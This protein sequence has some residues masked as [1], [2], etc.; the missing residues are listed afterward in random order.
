MALNKRLTDVSINALPAK[1]KEYRLHDSD[2]LYIRVKPSG[3]KSWQLRAKDLNGKWKWYGIG[4][5]PEVKLKTAHLK[6]MKVMNGEEVLLTKKEKKEEEMQQQKALFSQLMEEWL[7]TKKPVWSEK[8]YEKEVQSIHKHLIPV[9]GQLEFAEITSEQWLD[10][11]YEKQC[12]EGIPDRIEKL[13]SHCRNAYDLAK[14]KGKVLYNPL[15]GIGK[16]L[17]KPAGENLKFMELEDIPEMLSKIRAYSARRIGI[18]LEL[19]ILLF[20]RPQELRLA[21]WDHFDFNKKLWIKPASIMKQRKAHAVPLS[22]QA[23]TLLAELKAISSESEYLFPSRDSI[24][25][26]ISNLTFNA[27]LNRLGYKGKQHPHGFRHVASTYL[28]NEF[29]DKDQVVEAALSHSKRG[30]KSVYDKSTHLGERR[31]MMQNWGD[32]IESMLRS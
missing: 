8:T 20:P 21:C 16:F 28:N 6:A 31:I 1:D 19:L 4:S 17:A 13:V 3:K 27:A 5:Y 14:F 9:L 15:D 23:L 18:A 2:N 11:F 26:P 29:S 12:N 7:L 22:D 25:Q 30:V 10:F 24:S 32:K